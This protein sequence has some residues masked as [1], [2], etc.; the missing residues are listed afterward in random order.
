MSSY[1]NKSPV[2]GTEFYFDSGELI[3]INCNDWLKETGLTKNLDVAVAT[4]EF[5]IFITEDAFNQ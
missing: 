4:E 3:A 5:H 1:D 2:D